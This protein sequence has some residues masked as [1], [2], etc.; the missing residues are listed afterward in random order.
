MLFPT[1]PISPLFLFLFSFSPSPPSACVW[2]ALCRHLRLRNRNGQQTGSSVPFIAHGPGRLL[3]FSFSFSPPPP[4]F[5][6]R[7]LSLRI[8]KSL[9]LGSIRPEKKFP[10]TTQA[11]GRENETALPPF[12]F[13]LLFLHLLRVSIPAGDPKETSRTHRFRSRITFNIGQ[14]VIP[15]FLFF[16]YYPHPFLF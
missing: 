2:R 9:L 7:L 11:V 6:C 3:L 15:S 13:F 14:D 12:F 4:F 16:F 1:L 5:P 10:F 8:T